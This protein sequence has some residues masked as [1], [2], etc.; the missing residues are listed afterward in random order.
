M[1]VIYLG[2]SSPIEL[3]HGQEYVV[4]SVEDGWYRVVDETGEDYLYPPEDFRVSEE[5]DGTTPVYSI[6][7]IRKRNSEGY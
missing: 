3:L 2:D 5:N 6:E 7:D 1:K 4:L